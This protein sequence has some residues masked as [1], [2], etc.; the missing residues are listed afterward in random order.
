MLPDQVASANLARTG[1]RSSAMES[2]SNSAV[3]Q[4]EGQKLI[5]GEKDGAFSSSLEDSLTKLHVGCESGPL[6]VVQNASPKLMSSHAES[7]QA[8]GQI[9]ETLLASNDESLRSSVVVTANKFME[10]MRSNEFAADA[11]YVV[12]SDLDLRGVQN[13]ILPPGLHV[14]GDFRIGRK[15]EDELPEN[16]FGTGI[17]T[18]KRNRD[19]ILTCLPGTDNGDIKTSVP[20]DTGIGYLPDNFMVDGAFIASNCSG[21]LGFGNK[22]L[23]MKRCDIVDCENFE[24]LGKRFEVSNGSLAIR[25]SPKL[26]TLPEMLLVKSSVVLDKTGLIS[27]PENMKFHGLLKLVDCHDF[28]FIGSGVSVGSIVINNCEQFEQWPIDMTVQDSIY[29]TGL[30]GVMV[31]PETLKLSRDFFLLNISAKLPLDLNV[32]KDLIMD[33]TEILNVDD[34]IHVKVGFHVDLKNTAMKCV[35]SWLKNC[36]EPEPQ[37]EH[38]VFLEG[39]GLSRSGSKLEDS[40]DVIFHFSEP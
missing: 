27:I 31:F 6:A 23:I 14:R 16:L 10:L 2:V 5:K 3:K 20:D 9:P 1:E 19:F 8:P 26:K 25:Q 21:W 12:D 18:A 7:T 34:N 22:T 24:S 30:H 17:E 11:N 32:G 28:Q 37:L 13:V 4:V 35:P 40:K 15:D 33:S 36:F 29:L 39:T 38:H